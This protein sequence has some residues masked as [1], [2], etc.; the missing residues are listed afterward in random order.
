[1]LVEPAIFPGRRVAR[2][3]ARR[4]LARRAHEDGRRFVNW[5]GGMRRIADEASFPRDMIA[6]YLEAQRTA[7]AA[8]LAALLGSMHELYPL[9]YHAISVPTRVV[10]GAASGWRGHLL[11]TLARRRLGAD[12][13]AIPGAAHLIANEQD[14]A[15]AAAIVGA[16]G[17]W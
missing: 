12:L 11:C 13:V 17:T 10:R 8:S 3:A 1:V 15:L 5:N 16:G 9:P 2:A 14:E 6:L 7:D 4:Y